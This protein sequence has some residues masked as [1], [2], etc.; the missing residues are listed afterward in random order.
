MVLGGS[1]GYTHSTVHRSVSFANPDTGAL[2]NAIEAIGR[3]VTDF[4]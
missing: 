1:L 3:A 2:T 4:L